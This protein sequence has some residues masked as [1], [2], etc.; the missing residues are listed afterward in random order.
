MST[1]QLGLHPD[2]PERECPPWALSS[3]IDRPRDRAPNPELEDSEEEE[4]EEPS[5]PGK[6]KERAI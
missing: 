3:Y 6:G 5:V 2:D 1:G 4:V